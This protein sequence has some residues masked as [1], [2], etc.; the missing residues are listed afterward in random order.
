MAKKTILYEVV[1]KNGHG[2]STEFHVGQTKA[3]LKKAIETTDIKV[4]SI[5][6]LGQKIVDVQPDIDMDTEFNVKVSE[7]EG[8]TFNKESR[9][10]QFLREKFQPQVD[11]LEKAIDDTYEE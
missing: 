3:L 1:V 6:S 8:F 4:D 9:G 11:K 2:T 10:Y 5:K 7:S